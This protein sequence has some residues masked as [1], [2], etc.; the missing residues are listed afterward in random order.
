MITLETYI[1]DMVKEHPETVTLLIRRGV[2]C[3]KC[4]EPVWGTLG[5]AMDRANI[6]DQDEIINELNKII[7]TA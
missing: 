1:E 5:E 6:V 4:G 2:V 7:V 3:I